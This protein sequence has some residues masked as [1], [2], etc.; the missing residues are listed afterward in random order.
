[1]DTFLTIFHTFTQSFEVVSSAILSYSLT[2]FVYN[3]EIVPY[4][5]RTLLH[6]HLRNIECSETTGIY[7]LRIRQGFPTFSLPTRCTRSV[8]SNLGYT[9]IY[10]GIHENILNQSKRNA[11]TA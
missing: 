10:Y 4:W 11:G 6:G 8:V 2:L 1:M 5:S 3:S 7:A 9:K